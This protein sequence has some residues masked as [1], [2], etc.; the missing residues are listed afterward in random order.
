[1]GFLAY[2]DLLGELKIDEE[3]TLRFCWVK[4]FPCWMGRIGLVREYVDFTVLVE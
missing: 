1:M 4:Y 2:W 3:I